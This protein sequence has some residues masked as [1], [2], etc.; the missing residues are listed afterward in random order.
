MSREGMG[1]FQV[2]RNGFWRSQSSQ[3]HPQ[4]IV[5]TLALYTE[6][7]HGLDSKEMAR[8]VWPQG[9]ACGKAVLTRRK[10]V[11]SLI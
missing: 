3:H 4:T 9:W 7:G 8:M 11:L 5:S 10:L 2:H 1:V 6:M